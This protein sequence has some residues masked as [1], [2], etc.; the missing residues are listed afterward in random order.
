MRFLRPQVESWTMPRLKKAMRALLDSQRAL[1][2]SRAPKTL[3]FEEL[4]VK[5]GLLG[6][7]ED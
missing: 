6:A 3:I 5:L 2:T 4:A 7:G 1:V